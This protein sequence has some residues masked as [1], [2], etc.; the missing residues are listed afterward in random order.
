MA[1][2]VEIYAAPRQRRYFLS[3]AHQ[4]QMLADKFDI[5]FTAALNVIPNYRFQKWRDIEALLPGERWFEEIQSGLADSDFG[6]LLVSNHFLNSEF[7]RSQELPRYVP[8][9]KNGMAPKGGKF[10]IPVGLREVVNSD[11]L[12]AHLGSRQVYLYRQSRWFGDCSV[13]QRG[14]FVNTLVNQLLKVIERREGEL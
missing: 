11:V 8:D 6:V 3:Y 1:A 13:A 12:N 2:T 7:I 10:C 5:E 9:Q 14:H 4:D